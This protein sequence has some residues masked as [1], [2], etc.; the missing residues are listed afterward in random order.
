MILLIS[1]CKEKLHYYEFVKPVE[2]ILKNNNIQF[3]TTQYKKINRN[4]IKK[5]DKIIICGTSLKDNDFLKNINFFEWIKSYNKPLFCICGGMHILCLLFDGEL[6]KQKEIGLINIKFEKEFLGIKGAIPVYELHNLY[7]QCKE[8]D[9]Y[10]KSKKCPQAVKH[11]S[12]P[13]Y[14]VLFHPEV[15]TKHLILNFAKTSNL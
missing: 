9:L 5:S 10:A 6:K 1:I 2:D 11:K 13:F 8:F 15:R 4:L 14:G 3:K 12:K 7:V